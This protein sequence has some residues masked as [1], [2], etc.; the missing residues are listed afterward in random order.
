M[1]Y[2]HAKEMP[3]NRHRKTSKQINSTQ[4]TSEKLREQLPTTRKMGKQGVP[5]HALNWFKKQGKLWY[6]INED[7]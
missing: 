7:V 6:L 1:G 2:Q 4:Y 3:I 5:A